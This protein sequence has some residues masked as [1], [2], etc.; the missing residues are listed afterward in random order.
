MTKVLS[1][2]AMISC[3]VDHHVC[4]LIKIR[5]LTQFLIIKFTTLTQVVLDFPLDPSLDKITKK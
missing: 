1:K 4:K 2:I 5:Q 3:L